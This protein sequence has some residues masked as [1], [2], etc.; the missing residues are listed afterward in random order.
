MPALFYKD[1]Q[2]HIKFNCPNC[3][4]R[5]EFTYFHSMNKWKCLKCQFIFSRRENFF[6]L[7]VESLKRDYEI[8]QRLKEMRKDSK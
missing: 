3:K 7:F 2:V 6:S 1:E 4:V 8:E 5:V